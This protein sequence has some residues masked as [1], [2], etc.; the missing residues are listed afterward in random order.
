MFWI[1]NRL[2]ENPKLVCL[3]KEHL[4]F[5]PFKWY[6]SRIYLNST[7]NR[8]APFLNMNQVQTI[9]TPNIKTVQ[10]FQTNN[11]ISNQVFRH[12]AQNSRSCP[13]K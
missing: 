8:I 12:Q 6:S 10:K 3:D 13:E 11:A 9:T 5:P 4:E 7:S 2:M 1:Q